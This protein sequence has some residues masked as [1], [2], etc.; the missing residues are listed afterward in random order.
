MKEGQ[1]YI[2][3]KSSMA[4]IETVRMLTALAA[5]AGWKIY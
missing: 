3:S 4:A 1:H 2:A 5:G